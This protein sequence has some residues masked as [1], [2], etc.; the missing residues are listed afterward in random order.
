MA[1]VQKVSSYERSLTKEGQTAK[2]KEAARRAANRCRRQLG[3]TQ[4]P[5]KEDELS[6]WAKSWFDVKR[7]VRRVMAERYPDKYGNLDMDA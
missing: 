2:F 4:V 6:Q 1:A 3:L 5:A 7:A